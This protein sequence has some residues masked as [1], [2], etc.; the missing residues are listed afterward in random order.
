MSSFRLRTSLLICTTGLALV[1]TPAAAHATPTPIPNVPTPKARPKAPSGTCSVSV[2]RQVTVSAP[3]TITVRLASDCP[4]GTLARW[5]LV[6]SRGTIVQRFVFPP[7]TPKTI[8]V[9][10]P[11][12]LGTYTLRPVAA[13]APSYRRLGQ[14]AP[15][16]SVGARSRTST[17]AARAGSKVKVTAG[18]TAYSLAAKKFV[19]RGKA[20]VTL[21]RSTC[22]KGCPWTTVGTATT[23]A[24]GLASLTAS[25]RK[26]A[27]W[28]THVAGTPTTWGSVSSV[29]A[30]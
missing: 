24:R 30:R 8:S 9:T 26:V 5:N 1:A 28:R 13:S 16:I 18:A 20:T 7:S 11:K 3:T 27:Y 4:A 10:S 29:F 2:P 6:D 23:D 15:K 12:A 22:A 17:D 19:P 25:S 14:N 21:Q